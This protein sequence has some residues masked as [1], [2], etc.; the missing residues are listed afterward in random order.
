MLNHARDY[1]NWRWGCAGGA[2]VGVTWFH[3]YIKLQ[4]KISD[5]TNG[6]KDGKR[7]IFLFAL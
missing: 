6:S 2:S 3:V 4:L 7:D 5:E 1:A